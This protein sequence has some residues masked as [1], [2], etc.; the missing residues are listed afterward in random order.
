MRAA[1]T[2]LIGGGDLV[3]HAWNEHR[4]V[5]AVPGLQRV[6]LLGL[7]ARSFG[8]VNG[9]LLRGDDLRL[10]FPT[11]PAIHRTEPVA[12]VEGVEE[13]RLTVVANRRT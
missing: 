7:P 13:F 5:N 11:T 2:G 6:R 4:I 8:R 10:C 3:R 1:V 9:C 12:F